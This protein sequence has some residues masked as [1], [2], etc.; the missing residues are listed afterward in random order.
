[1]EYIYFE[2]NIIRSSNPVC[3]QR[4]HFRQHFAVFLPQVQEY[5][6][7]TGN[8]NDQ[9]QVVSLIFSFFPSSE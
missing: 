8:V 6:H 9:F 1:M 4:P 5:R 3:Y 2:I 7:Q